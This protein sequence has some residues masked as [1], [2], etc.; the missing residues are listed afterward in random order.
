MLDNFWRIF[1]PFRGRWYA[2]YMYVGCFLKKSSTT[3]LISTSLHKVAI[4]SDV[5]RKSFTLR[6]TAS[7]TECL[8]VKNDLHVQSL[9]STSKATLI[10][11]LRK[12][13]VSQSLQF[14]D[15]RLN[16]PSR[17][18][19]DYHFRSNIFA[20]L[21]KPIFGFKGGFVHGESLFHFGY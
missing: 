18:A 4:R 5:I 9:F 15:C 16:S 7:S 2:T 8:L 10:H 3:L 21:R 11:Y 20:R 19:C 17:P 13:R 1:P 12:V 6:F 14:R